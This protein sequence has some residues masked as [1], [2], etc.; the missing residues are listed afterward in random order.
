MIE[1]NAIQGEF[2]ASGNGNSIVTGNGS[3][4]IEDNQIF[5]EVNASGNGNS[6]FADGNARSKTT[7]ISGEE[8]ASGNGN[9]VFLDGTRT[10]KTTRSPARAMPAPTAIALASRFAN[11][12]DNNISGED[13]A[14]GNGNGVFVGIAN[15]EDNNIFGDGQRQRQRQR[16]FV[17]IANIEDNNISGEDNASENG[18]GGDVRHS[19]TSKTTPS[20]A[21]TMPASNGNGGPDARLRQDR[22]QLHLR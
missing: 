18:N 20:P 10:S 4:T 6:V 14:S 12:E 21:R 15:I 11:I 19:P 22:G 7:N 13:N 8:N 16:L 17:G 3:A 9:S 1:N 5:G 2:N